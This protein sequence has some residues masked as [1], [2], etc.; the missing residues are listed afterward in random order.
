MRNVV[1]NSPFMKKVHYILAVCAAAA[2]CATTLKAG[3]GYGYSSDGTY[4][5]WYTSPGGSSYGYDSNRTYYNWYTSPGGSSYGYNSN[6]N[7][8]NWYQR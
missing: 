4:Y 6:G 2:I 8:Y 3:S 1:P 7:Y 5:N